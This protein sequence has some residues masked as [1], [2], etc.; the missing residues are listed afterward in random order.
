MANGIWDGIE[1]KIRPGIYFLISEAVAAITGGERGVVAIPLFSFTGT[2]KKGEFYTI[3][4]EKDAIATFGVEGAKPVT[5]VLAG[6][7]KSALVYAADVKVPEL[8]DYA[9]IRDLYEARAFNVFVYPTEVSADEQDAMTAW[10]KRCREQEGRHFFSVIGGT[11]AEDQ[12]VAVGN[13]R[14]Q[15]CKDEYVIN[16][17]NGAITGAG[18]EL[19]SGIY[20]AY[21]GGLVAGTPINKSVTYAELPVADVNKRFKNSEIESALKAGSL[22]LVNDGSRVKI[23]QGITTYKS[24]SKRG[25]IRVQ[26]GIQAILTDISTTVAAAY[27]GKVDNNDAGQTAI[28]NAVKLYL[29]TLESQNVLTN[30]TVE[31]D[32]DNASVDDRLYLV[33]S[34]VEVDSMEFVYLKINV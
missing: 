12:D 21:I 26:S 19:H 2:A 34:Y 32:P 33:L 10:T 29:E 13:A 25:K 3:E 5:R 1:Q 17:I 23:E 7:A 11:V 6:G 14:S 18:D 30:P 16:L 24:E 9:A 20:A 27:I 15:R 8:P 4:S 22:V 31:L 28:I